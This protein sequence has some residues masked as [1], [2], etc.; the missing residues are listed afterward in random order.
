MPQLNTVTHFIRLS[1]F[2]VFQ[3][4]YFVFPLIMM[5]KTR[6]F[7][8]RS[9]CVMR[10]FSN[11][12]MKRT[13]LDNY[14]RPSKI[15]R[16]KKVI[17]FEAKIFQR[18]AFILITCDHNFITAGKSKMSS[19]FKQRYISN[20]WLLCECKI[21]PHFTREIPFRQQASSSRTWVIFDT[22]FGSE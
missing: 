19:D 16:N 21:I 9:F 6:G 7:L 5:S 13:A 22:F 11:C 20:S 4:Y 2:I 8:N 1:P 3:I 15:N 18:F 17:T 10:Y 12:S 14:S